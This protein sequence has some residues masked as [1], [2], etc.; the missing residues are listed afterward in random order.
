MLSFTKSLEHV[1]NILCAISMVHK[2]FHFLMEE[3]F[4][5]TAKVI[6]FQM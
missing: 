4:V 5:Q 1:V 6:L 3:G 2:I